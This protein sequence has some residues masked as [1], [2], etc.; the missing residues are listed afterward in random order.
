MAYV[1]ARET[2]APPVW[3]RGVVNE[4]ASEGISTGVSHF[5]DRSDCLRDLREIDSKRVWIPSYQKAE[6]IS[7][8]FD[9]FKLFSGR[10]M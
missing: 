5:I 6:S 2:N 1:V 9:L 10:Y 7:S 4:E 8:V 3:V